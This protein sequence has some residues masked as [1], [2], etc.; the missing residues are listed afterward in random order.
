MLA[1]TVTPRQ[2]DSA[3]LEEIREP[4]RE[5]G[6]ILVRTLAI[7][8]CGTDREILMGLYGSAPPGEERLVLGHESLGE[9]MEAPIESGLRVGDLV[10]GI[11]RRADPEPCAACAVGEWDM[12][13]NGLFTE[14]GIKE[15]DGF[16][17]ERFRLH[18]QACAPVHGALRSSGVLLE[19][20]SVV[21]KAWDHIESIGARTRSWRLRRVLVTGAGPIGLLAALMAMQR[22]GELHVYDRER[23]G[24]KPELVRRLGGRYHSDSIEEACLIGPDVIVECTG[25]AE[26]IGHV[27]SRNARGAIVCLAGLSSGSHRIPFDLRSLNQSMVLENDVVFGS[28]N[29]NR[30]HYVLAA[31]ALA[32]ADPTWLDALIT[33][34]VS[35]RNWS[36]ALERLRGDIKV[37][38]DFTL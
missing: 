24:P 1:L 7:G 9:V 30:S 25:A 36:E 15:L 17:A 27:M 10:A 31:E 23:S 12:C 35:L 16:C 3:A 29:A 8:V 22:G 2:P 26:I 18:P 13:R 32:R 37:V 4:D 19:P 14:H 6:A 38:I 20:A 5:Q 34:R 21:A 11:V 28:V 33:R